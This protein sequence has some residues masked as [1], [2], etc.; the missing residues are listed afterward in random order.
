MP[1]TLVV[2]DDPA[3]RALI[4]APN[5]GVAD[6]G[7]RTFVFAKTE[8][9][10]LRIM[11]SESDLDIALVTIDSAD[12]SG[13]D[14]FK[15]LGGVKLRVP[16]IA[17][18]NGDD[19]TRIR[20]AMNDGASDFLTKPLD[21]ADLALTIDKAWADCQRRR[22]AWQTEAQLAAI[23]REIDI[24]GEIQKR[25]LP[26]EFPSG[27]DF[28]I[29]AEIRPAKEMGG[30]FYDF[31]E[32]GENKLGLVVADVSGKGV[33]AAFF[34]AVARTL[35]QA[36]A[37][38]VDNPNDCLEQV[39]TLLYRHNI[40]GMFVSVFYGILDTKRWVLDYA[41]GGHLPPYL[42]PADGGDVIT[43]EGGDGVVLGITE[44]VPYEKASIAISK[45]DALF[46]YTDGLTEAFDVDR[47]QFSDERLIRYLLE[48]RDDNA[49]AIAENVFAFVNTFTGDAPQSD[50]ITSLVIKRF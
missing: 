17:L 10:A 34:M 28:D 1:K 12:I 2:D 27:R 48:H 30:D 3:T 45:G 5:A 44:D 41:N 18:T 42:V 29:R 14:L 11:T 25:I 39:N 19:L 43:L 33:P 49:T 47:N 16:R 9:E 38:T 23:R 32:L 37:M 8:E 40:P 13:M 7:R 15:R 36:T 20:K 24:A 22:E 6:G 21:P 26:R 35:I 50:D 4:E 31:F 46:F